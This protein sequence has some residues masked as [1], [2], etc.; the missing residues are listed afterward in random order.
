MESKIKKYELNQ[1]GKK[2]VLSIQIFEDKLRF[3]CI[4]FSLEKQTVFI[5]EF[6]IQDL[7]KISS[8]FSGL[9]EITKALE[10]FDKLI[11]NQKVNV[12]VKENY[13]NLNIIIK[14]E[15]QPDEIVT[16]KLTL[17]N[18][19]SKIIQTTTTTTTT[20]NI[21]DNNLSINQ[22]NLANENIINEKLIYS[23]MIHNSEKEKH[24]SQEIEQNIKSPII[25]NVTQ[26]QQLI[27]SSNNIIN[28]SNEQLIHSPNINTE[29]NI[30]SNYQ[31]QLIQLPN[32][33]TDINTHEQQFIETSNDINMIS[34]NQNIQ[35]DNQIINTQIEG[36]NINSQENQDI[37]NADIN[38]ASSTDDYIQQFLQSQGNMSSQ[39]QTTAN[40]EQYM[41][42]T[43]DIIDSNQ[44]YN[45]DYNF[46]LGSQ[47]EQITNTQ[48]LS[49]TQNNTTTD[50]QFIEQPTQI[51]TNVS[52]QG[53]YIQQTSTTDNNINSL[54]NYYQQLVSNN[55]TQNE[56]I[57]SYQQPTTITSNT[58]TSQTQYVQIPTTKITTQKQ[59][60]V[61]NQPIETQTINYNTT[62]NQVKKTKKIKTEKIVL[63]LLPQPQEAPV[64]PK[65]EETNYESSAQIYAPIQQP[66]IQTPQI[67]YKDNPELDT[68]REEN[69]RLKQEISILKSQT[70]IKSE[71]QVNY[72]KEVLLLREEIERL[73][74]EL[75]GYTEYKI[76]KEDEI[77]ML[78]I[79]IRN[80]L[81]RIKEL[82]R[83]IKDLRAHIEKLSQLKSGSETTLGGEALSIQDTRLEIIRGDII[84]NAKELELLTR[85]MCNGQYS[86]IS[87]DL[88]YKAIIDSDKASIFH[89][90]C[91]SA[92]STLVLVK[93]ANGK[94]FGGFTSCNWQGNSIEKKDENAFIFSLD[95]LKIYNII[96]GEDAIGCYPN[97]GPVFLGCQIRIYDEF[98]KNGGTTFEKGMNFDTEEDFELTGG[99]KKFD[100]KDIE[101]YSVELTM[102]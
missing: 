101:V 54:D 79:K 3:A 29:V 22:N 23:P 36:L 58:T 63:S 30:N 65:I 2:Y 8:F 6:K 85:R 49:Q 10:L 14:K 98:F 13:I 11:M 92:K 64:E 102:Q 12:E 84:E 87:L 86:K 99:L 91:D 62:Q 27:N 76:Q 24:I 72:N 67:I 16:I 38:G 42:K 15:N 33:T 18:G 48:I 21:I 95:K 81:S 94:R 53:Q 37:K 66:E 34:Q 20:T 35:S 93:S 82:E 5:G 68:L 96:P 59:Y 75:R 4:E 50:N 9:T 43:Q 19:S 7:I 57:Q 71:T 31:E 51:E 40:I 73:R 45:Q 97:F 77:N 78:N 69:A 61:Q 39:E 89:K 26:E 83:M 41:Q 90:K 32:N 88:L 56:Y 46:N 70:V 25:S 74:M 17:F 60:I 1:G 47:E 55:T 52:S 80:L 44:Q 28:A 100:I